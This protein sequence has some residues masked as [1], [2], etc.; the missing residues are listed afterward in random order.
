MVSSSQGTSLHITQVVTS[1]QHTVL[2]RKPPPTKRLTTWVKDDHYVDLF[3]S[4]T[5][6]LSSRSSNW[7]NLP[8]ET[9]KIELIID[10]RM[11][12]K[13]DA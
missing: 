9:L 1:G 10:D 13:E 4:K 2:R 7:E 12:L 3:F 8:I 6:L 5:R 11:T